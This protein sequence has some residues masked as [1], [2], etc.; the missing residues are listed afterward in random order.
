MRGRE[1][2]K[3]KK[4]GKGNDW[5]RGEAI[6]TQIPGVLA[7]DLCYGVSFGRRRKETYPS[8]ATFWWHITI[9]SRHFSAYKAPRHIDWVVLKAICEIRR[10][11]KCHAQF[12]MCYPPKGPGHPQ[13]WRSS[14]LFA[15]TNKPLHPLINNVSQ[16][17]PLEL[18]LVLNILN[19]PNRADWSPTI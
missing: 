14:A 15:T 12:H 3:V 5:K 13:H 4:K 19:L 10:C 16:V 7:N 9:S 17:V 18:K 8:P 11:W 1:G 2:V 6:C